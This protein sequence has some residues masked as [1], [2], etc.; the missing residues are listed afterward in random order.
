MLFKHN[1]LY[2]K[3]F[4]PDGEGGGGAGA[5]GNEGGEGDAGNIGDS[6]NDD[7]GD[8]GGDETSGLKTALEK[9]RSDRKK[10]ERDLKAA[11]KRIAEFENANKSE[12][13]RLSEERDTFKTELEQIQQRYRE[14]LA[15][16]AF[17]DAAQKANAISP[18]LLFRAYRSELAYDEDGQVTNLADVLDKA[19]ADERALF[20]NGS[21]DGGKS[22]PITGMDMNAALRDMAQNAP[23]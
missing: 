14:T 16:T 20:K 18:R 2:G 8:D 12:L 11:Q 7:S 19:K 13:E 3:F 10:F 23:R 4:S 5:S 21:G 22:G 15:E 17:V 6:G 9:E 1:L